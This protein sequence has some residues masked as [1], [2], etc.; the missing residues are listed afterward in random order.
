MEQPFFN[1]NLK[2]STL[3]TYGTA[4]IDFVDMSEGERVAEQQSEGGLGR[5]GKKDRRK[6]EEG[7]RSS[8]VYDKL[9][10]YSESPPLIRAIM[11]ELL[12]LF[13]RRRQTVYSLCKQRSRCSLITLS[14]ESIPLDQGNVMLLGDNSAPSV[15]LMGNHNQG[16][17]PH[18]F[19]ERSL[20]L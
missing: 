13:C 6:E 18:L 7:E 5:C 12:C 15:R 11:H 10:E 20:P 14:R 3:R 16:H 9:R 4:E 19:L 2:Q 8:L 17:S 1:L